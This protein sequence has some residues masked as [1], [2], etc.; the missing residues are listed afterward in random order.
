M[1]LGIFERVFCVQAATRGTAFA[2]ERAGKQYLITASHVFENLQDEDEIQILRGGGYWPLPVRVVGRSAQH[3]VLVLA[4]RSQ[5]CPRYGALA[6]PIR[7]TTGQDAY[8][9]GFPGE[10]VLPHRGGDGYPMSMVKRATI[11]AILLSEDGNDFLI[12]GHAT[13]GF[14]GGPLIYTIPGF[15]PKVSQGRI[16]T[17]YFIAG[18]VTNSKTFLQPLIR[19][20]RPLAVHAE[21]P[22]GIAGCCSIYH[23]NRLIDANPTG[24]RLP[25][26][27]EFDRTERGRTEGRAILRERLRRLYGNQFETAFA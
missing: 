4:T 27:E 24:Y 20:E 8:F 1:N 3:D 23:A 22:I 14:S 7:L 18:L 16:L 5:L 12:D 11:S 25:D 15:Q 17:D 19:D 13:N 26:A 6:T 9:L 10:D 21:F 2:V